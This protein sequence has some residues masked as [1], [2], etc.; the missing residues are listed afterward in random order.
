MGAIIS[1]ATMWREVLYQANPPSLYPQRAER[2]R[3]QAAYRVKTFPRLALFVE[4]DFDP[5]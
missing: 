1:F 3:V 4:F 2:G 5:K